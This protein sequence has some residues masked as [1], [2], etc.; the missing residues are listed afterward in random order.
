MFHHWAL[1]AL[2]LVLDTDTLLEYTM[3]LTIVMEIHRLEGEG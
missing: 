1:Q 3:D 2:G